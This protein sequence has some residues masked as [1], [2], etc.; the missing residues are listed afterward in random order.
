MVHLGN[1]HMEESIENETKDAEF[2][3]M[4]CHFLFCIFRGY[5]DWEGERKI[6]GGF[7]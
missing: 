1:T 7:L 5:V 2:A 3:A 6:A 4:L